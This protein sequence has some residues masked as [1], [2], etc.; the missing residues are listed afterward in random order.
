MVV[1]HPAGGKGEGHEDGLDASPSLQAKGCAAVIDE[2]KLD[3]AA[4]A[5][6]LPLLLLRGEGIVLVLDNEGAVGLDNA[7]DAVCGE[8][9]DRLG[10]LVV[11]VVE[12]DASQATSLTL[13][14][15]V[16]GK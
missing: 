8:L 3:V 9:E 7:V 2:V 11:Q 4:A 16:R 14:G 10:I 12:K 1:I 6:L 13:E 15:R 5:E